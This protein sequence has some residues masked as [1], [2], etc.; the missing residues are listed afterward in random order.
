MSTDT[1]D[2]DLQEN[3]GTTFIPADTYRFVCGTRKVIR[4]GPSDFRVVCATCEA[5]GSVR[6]DT[7]TQAATAAVRD[8][9]RPCLACGAS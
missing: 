3:N 6:H 4:R 9:N 7:N 2:R 8:S 5:G 1:K